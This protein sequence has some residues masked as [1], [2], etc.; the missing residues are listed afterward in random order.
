MRNTA[1]YKGNKSS[2]SKNRPDWVQSQLIRRGIKDER[3]L[4]AFAQ[5]PRRYFIPSEYRDLAE[6]DGP[7]SIGCQQTVSQPYVVALTLQ[8]LAL[9]GSETVL[10]VGTG[11]GYQTVLLSYLAREV[12]TIEIHQSLY[13]TSRMVLQ[14]R[15]MAPVH[16][17]HGD[18]S[19]GWPEAAP[20]D[21]IVAGCYAERP[22]PAL[23][24]QLAPEGRLVMPIGGRNNQAL[25][26]IIRRQ[27]GTLEKSVLDRVVFVP[28]LGE[29]GVQPF[30]D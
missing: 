13:L 21:A 29:E 18:G 3:V 5:V 11:S 26:R 2:D 15:A 25:Y 28:L 12:Y 19:L 23:L 30:M 16:T 22:P 4:D 27:D 7:I 10:D 8:A 9:T 6:S 17:R 1:N 20:F 24:R 14:E